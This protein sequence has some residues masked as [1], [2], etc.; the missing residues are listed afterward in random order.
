MKKW[1]IGLVVVIALIGSFFA[2][3][4]PEPSTTTAVKSASTTRTV[5]TSFSQVQ[6]AIA[7]GAQLFDVR[8]A[9]EYTS[10]HIEGAINLSLQDIQAGKRPTGSKNQ[11]IY[12]YCHSGNRSSQATAILQGVGY[13]NVVDLGAITKV[14]SIGGKLV[15]GS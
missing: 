5:P 10:G 4:K 14:E 3:S 13:S 8:T 7:E 12:V 9:D 11:T 1:V 6:T 2:F 15:A